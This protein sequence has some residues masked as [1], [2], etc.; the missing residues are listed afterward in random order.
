VTGER[1]TLTIE[2]TG[3]LLGIS[4]GLAYSA[5]RSGDIPTVRCGRRLLVP[6][7]AF[8]AL[9]G[10]PPSVP[11]ETGGGEDEEGV[12]PAAATVNAAADGAQ[13][14]GVRT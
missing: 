5:A 3:K 9:L 8:Y 14:N 2:E 7:A 11:D 4:R 1:L 10:E 6:K 13:T 12:S